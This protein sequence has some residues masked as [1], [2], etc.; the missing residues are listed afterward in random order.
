[1][2]NNLRIKFLVL[3][4]IF[5]SGLSQA[6]SMNFGIGAGMTHALLGPKIGYEF[7]NGCALDFS[8]SYFKPDLDYAFGFCYNG[9]FFNNEVYLGPRITLGKREL[10]LSRDNGYRSFISLYWDNGLNFLKEIKIQL[11]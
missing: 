6:G 11:Y 10:E 9:K 1:L 5:L 7:E 2:S 4:L 8:V 3:V